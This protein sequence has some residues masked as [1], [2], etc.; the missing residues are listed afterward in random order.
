MLFIVDQRLSDN[1]F[2]SGYNVVHLLS[3]AD[4]ISSFQCFRDTLC[5][6]QLGNQGFQAL[7][8]LLVH[9]GKICPKIAGQNQVVEPDGV[10]FFEIVPV[11]TAPFAD[12]TGFLR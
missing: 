2:C 1:C 8:G 5:G 4:G 7:L 10:V 3:P 11:H 12:G 9:V 6:Y